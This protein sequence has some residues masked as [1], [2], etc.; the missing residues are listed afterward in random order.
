M[1]C[2]DELRRFK[3]NRIFK[4]GFKIPTWCVNTTVGKFQSSRTL[5]YSVMDGAKG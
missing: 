2:P 4:K 3:H 1:L 5:G